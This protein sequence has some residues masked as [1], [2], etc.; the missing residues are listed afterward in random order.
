MQ[1][2][3]AGKFHF[4]PP[5]TSLDHLVSAGEQR[6][7]HSEAEHLCG[8]QV[9]DE[10]EL[11]RL[12]HR[13]IS[14]LGAPENFIDVAGGTPKQISEICPIRH[15][16]AGCHIFSKSMKRWQSLPGR[17]V[18]NELHVIKSERVFDRYQCIWTLPSQRFDGAFEAL[19]RQ[20]PDALITVED[21]L[22][23]N[24]MKLIADFAAGQRLPTLHGFREDVAAGALMSYGA[25]LAD[26]FRRAAG[27]VDK[28]LRGAKPADLPVQQPT[29]FELVIN[30]RTAK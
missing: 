24:Y 23:F 21:P 22:T 30:L 6:R 29:K 17:E 27:Y 8:P 19:R 10:L 28:I 9:D 4:E 26:L 25:N 3:S 12:L 18:S 11:G 1:K 13:E 7:R 16:R 15:E 20:R 5:F 14:G 2:L